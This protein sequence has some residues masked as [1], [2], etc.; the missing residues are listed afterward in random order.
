MAVKY[1]RFSKVPEGERIT[2][3]FLLKRC[4]A[5]YD[6]W[7]EKFLKDWPKRCDG[8][9]AFFEGR[10]SAPPYYRCKRNVKAGSNFCHNHGYGDVGSRW[11]MWRRRTSIAWKALKV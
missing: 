3:E 7:V 6:G 8:V 9:V 10:D 5:I 1:S 2:K 11:R 4:G